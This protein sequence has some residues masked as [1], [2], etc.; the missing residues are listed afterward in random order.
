MSALYRDFSAYPQPI[1]RQLEDAQ[2]ARCTSWKAGSN[3]AKVPKGK[4][5]RSGVIV[6]TLLSFEPGNEAE[7]IVHAETRFVRTYIAV[8][9]IGSF[10]TRATVHWRLFGRARLFNVTTGLPPRAVAG[11]GFWRAHEYRADLDAGHGNPRAFGSRRRPCRYSWRRDFPY[12]RT[13]PCVSRRVSIGPE[14][15]ARV[16]ELARRR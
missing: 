9:W 14:S 5:E 8:T 12:R 16:Y 10:L 13:R 2:Y 11:S 3:S 15:I 1:R 6:K 4:P 7:K